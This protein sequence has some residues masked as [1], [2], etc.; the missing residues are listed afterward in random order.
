MNVIVWR[1][2]DSVD[3]GLVRLAFDAQN[4]SLYAVTATVALLSVLAPCV[5]IWRTGV[6]PRWLVALGAV[7]IAVNLVEL[8]GMASRTGWNAA[9]FVFGLGP[10][11][12]MIWVAALSITMMMRAPA[13]TP[14]PAPA[15][16][17]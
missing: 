12:W 16:A 8:A 7:E 13:D 15:V 11:V 9:G 14:S 17:G 4:L 2:A 5:V 6:L 1:G 3:P 10:L